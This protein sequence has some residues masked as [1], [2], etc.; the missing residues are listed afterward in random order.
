MLKIC[1]NQNINFQLKRESTD[2]KHFNNSK[3][4]IEHSNDMDDIY[5]KIEEYNPNRKRKILIVL[6]DMIA[7][8]FRNKKLSPII[9]ELSKS[10]SPRYLQKV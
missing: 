1:I 5:K 6:D 2:L 4:F 3:A 7:D 10:I 9:T 8:M